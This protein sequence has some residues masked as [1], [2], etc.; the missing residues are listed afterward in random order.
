MSK[1]VQL[2]ITGQVQGVGLR[3]TIFN[4]AKENNLKGWIR[5]EPDNTVSCFLQNDE[6]QVEKFIIWLRRKMRGIEDIA[7]NWTDNEAIFEDFIIKYQ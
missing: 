2:K 7:A 1:T 5:N 4:Y 3:Y 6:S